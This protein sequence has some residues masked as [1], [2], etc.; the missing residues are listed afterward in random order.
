MKPFIIWLVIAI[1]LFGGLS[2]F[3]HYRMMINPQKILVALDTSYSM[4]DVWHKIPTIL[5]ELEKR[6]YTVFCLVSEKRIIHGWSDDLNPGKINPY[7]PRDFS[8]LTGKNHYPEI[9][10]ADKKILITTALPGETRNFK[11]WEIIRIQ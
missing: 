6:P 9:E 8:K 2:G 10:K 7:A 4:K 5:K 1:I 11:G 3:T